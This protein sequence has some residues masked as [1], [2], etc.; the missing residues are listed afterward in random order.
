M[1]ILVT[2]DDG[3]H[4]PGLIALASALDAAGHDV[5]AVAPEGD[6]S[7]SGA[8]IGV[9]LDG[10][11]VRYRSMPLVGLEGVESIE[12]DGPP[13]L[14]VFAACLGA[15]GDPPELVASGLNP[16]LNTGRLT[17]HSGTVGAALTAANLGLSAVATSIA[18]REHSIE[19]WDVAGALAVQVVEWLAGAEPSTVVN[20]SVPDVPADELGDVR[21]G[22]LAPFGH[23]RAEITGR[24]EERLEFGFVHTDE[25]LPPGSD[26]VLVAQG[27]PVV[28]ALTGIR[29][30]EPAGLVEHLRGRGA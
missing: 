23:V 22:T 5:V 21:Y 24:T 8:A 25:V 27:H 1:R 20:L 19:H 26:A 28:T 18:G 3:L 2:N 16:G 13:A 14:C 7:G 6:R 29:G 10:S 30:H 9:L 15:F 4:A 12:L 17:L 11:F